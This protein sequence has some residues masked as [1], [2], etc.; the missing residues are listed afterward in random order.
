MGRRKALK[1]NKLLSRVHHALYCSSL[2]LV[3]VAAIIPTPVTAQTVT[4][5]N[6]RVLLLIDRSGSV[7]FDVDKAF[8]RVAEKISTM[9]KAG[10]ELGVAYI[11]SQTEANPQRMTIKAALPPGYETMGGA[12][13][14]SARMK[15]QKQLLMER[16]QMKATL[17]K[18][19]NTAANANTQES[20]DVWGSLA[21]MNTFFGNASTT[22]NCVVF[23]ISD[24]I[25]SMPGKERRDFHRQHPTN[26][27]AGLRKMA[28]A[29]V[30]KIRSIYGVSSKIPLAQVDQLAVL[31]PASGVQQSQN[32]AM[33]Q[34][35]TNVFELLGLS[36]QKMLFQ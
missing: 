35:W 21:T 1:L 24:L 23:I 11:H 12:T 30:P 8:Q 31:F 9:T 2:L 15:L 16:G 4:A 32:N 19:L 17:R 22:D 28:V 13:Q 14:S 5:G 34:Y 29:D 26:D 36:R 25:E 27:A 18:M 6:T 3:L 10:D 33:T 20:S 7:H